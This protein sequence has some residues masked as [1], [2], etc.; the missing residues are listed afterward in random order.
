MTE[1][2]RFEL[3]YTN[4]LKREYLRNWKRMGEEK[5]EELIQSGSLANLLKRSGLARWK[6]KVIGRKGLS[7]YNPQI[8]QVRKLIYFRRLSSQGKE[9]I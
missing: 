5:E 6:S 7:V 3:N 1:I 4:K 2:Y 8:D 9:L